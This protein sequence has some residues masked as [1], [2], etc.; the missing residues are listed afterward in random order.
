M[1]TIRK[2]SYFNCLEKCPTTSFE[3]KPSFESELLSCDS[4]INLHFAYQPL[5]VEPE[6]DH[7]FW[8]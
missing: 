5:E 7:H 4:E 1:S 2:K 6:I 3:S 8:F